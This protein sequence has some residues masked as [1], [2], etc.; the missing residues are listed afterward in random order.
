MNH[1]IISLLTIGKETTI[2][3]SHNRINEMVKVNWGKREPGFPVAGLLTVLG[4]YLYKRFKSAVRHS[5]FV[6]RQS[7]GLR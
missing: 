3:L 4:L 6:N 7:E 5:L 2:T 1:I